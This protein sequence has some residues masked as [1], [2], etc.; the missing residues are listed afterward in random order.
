MNKT[1]HVLA[2]MRVHTTF[3]C[4]CTGM[5]VHTHLWVHMYWHKWE[6][7]LP[8]SGHVLGSTHAPLRAHVLGVPMYLWVHTYWGVHTH[9][10]VRTYWGV[11]TYLWVRP[12]LPLGTCLGRSSRSPGV[13]T[14]PGG[15]RHASQDSQTP[16][17]I[18]N[19]YTHYHYIF[20]VKVLSHYSPH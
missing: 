18:D 13:P 10:W 6:C 12:R 7:T 9:R 3:E 4:T 19:T 8:L 20:K 16:V 17:H 14:P 1:T 11:H 2:L 5:E 15:Y